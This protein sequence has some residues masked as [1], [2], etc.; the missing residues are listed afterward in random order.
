MEDLR[1]WIF[2]SDGKWGRHCICP[3]MGR[4]DWN[5]G[6]F[7]GE[8]VRAWCEEIKTQQLFT[9]VAYAQGNGQVEV[10]NRTIVHA[11]KARLGEAQGSWAD[12]LPSV[13]WSYKTTTN[14]TTKE[15][16]Y[17]MVYGTEAVLP[18]KIGQESSRI[19]RYG[20]YNDN[21]RAMDLDLVEEK[22]E[23]ARVR[24]NACRIR[25]IRTYN[26]MLYPGSSNKGT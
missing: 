7:C 2:L 17:S 10:T 16:P 19:T 12:E 13:L 23:R 24:M 14:T 20:S 9:S 3:L 18:T 25:M 1:R 8:K 5:F 22:K 15:T 26:K 6:Q 11:L 4:G 21:L